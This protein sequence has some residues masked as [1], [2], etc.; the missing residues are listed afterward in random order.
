MYIL[1]N[2][3]ILIRMESWTKFDEAPLNFN[4]QDNLR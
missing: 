2:F 4:L 3:I 1:K